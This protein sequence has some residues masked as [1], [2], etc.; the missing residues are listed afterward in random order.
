MIQKRM[1]E[2][3]GFRSGLGSLRNAPPT[4]EDPFWESFSR[5]NLHEPIF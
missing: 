1:G 5:Q 4:T 2:S 3:R